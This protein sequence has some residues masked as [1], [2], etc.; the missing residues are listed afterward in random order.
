MTMKLQI[1]LLCLLPLSLL[2]CAGPDKDAKDLPATDSGPV[3]QDSG[4]ATDSGSDSGTTP[5]VCE[6]LGLDARPFEAAENSTDLSA[7]AADFEVETTQGTWR[8]SENWS[9]CES[10]LL[11]QDEP[12]QA[13]GWPKALWERDVGELLEALPKNTHVL[14]FSNANSK[15]TREENLAALEKKVKK[16]FKKWST[17]DADWR[18]DRL[19]YVTSKI[20]KIEAWPGIV[21][22]SPGWGVGIDRFQRI[23][24]I[25][26]YADPTRYNSDAGWFEPNLSMAANEAI[27]YN[28]E[29]ERA[30]QLAAQNA[31]VFPIWDNETIGCGWTGNCIYT[32]VELPD[33]ATMATYDTLELDMRMNCQGE[34][35]YGDCPPWDYL[36]YLKLCENEDPESCPVEFGRWI[37]TYHREGRWVHDI[38]GLLPLIQS[39][40]LQNFAFET[41]QTYEISL[42]FRLS[43]SGKTERP[44]SISPL[45]SGSGFHSTSNDAYIPMEIDIPASAK[46]VE[47][48]YVISGHGMSD[49]GNCAEFCVT[50]HDF[51]VNGSTHRVSLS[52]AAAQYGCMEQ[53]KEGTIPNQYGTWWYGRSNWCPGR[54]V[55]LKTIDISEQITPG[56]TA[57]LSYEGFYNGAAY[58]A[59]GASIRLKSWVVVSE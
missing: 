46:K 23:R 9:G 19:H 59:G 31:D 13:S 36:V 53:V 56:E 26:S 5:T 58:P 3:Q 40:G 44:V 24:Y 49:P 32:S 15:S 48:A 38:S 21:L 18:T 35:E 10:F 2:A 11:I 34:G 16:A 55:Q 39:G 30:L 43:N 7:V 52:D 14:F 51:T 45:F 57:T 54:E 20:R 29:A 28:F 17:E 25:G 8:F 22:G 50:D 41:T 6:T 12:R 27:Y 47:L 4:T 37:T 1:P 42:S 33:A